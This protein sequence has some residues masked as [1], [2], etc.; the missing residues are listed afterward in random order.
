MDGVADG[1]MESGV[2]S[3]QEVPGRKLRFVKLDNLCNE[4]RLQHITRVHCGPAVGHS[5]S[6]ACCAVP[7]SVTGMK[8]SV[9]GESQVSGETGVLEQ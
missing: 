4:G 2:M 8:A 1:T 6:T 3:M 5:S 9:V 7:D